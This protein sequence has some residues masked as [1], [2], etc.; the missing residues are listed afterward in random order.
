MLVPVYDIQNCGPRH[1]FA[2]NGKLVHNSDKVNL[3]N[4]PRKSPLKKAIRA[5]DGYLLCDCDSSQI[6]ARV[7]AWMAGQEDL[8]AAFD[9]GE[10]VY[11][12][13]ASSIYSVPVEEVT[14][15]QRFVGKAIILGCGYGMGANKFQM[16]LKSFGIDLALEEC[17]RIIS[18]YR[19]TYTCIPRLWGEADDAINAMLLG[20]S[21]P[22]GREGVLIVDGPNGII[23]PNTM[24]MQYPNLQRKPVLGSTDTEVTYDTRK[25]RNWV[26]NYIYG[27]KCVE[28]LCQAL[29]R[30][31]I[32]EQMLMVARRYKVAMTVHDSV[33]AL[34][35]EV[36]AEEARGYIEDCM[37][38]RPKWAMGLPLNCESKMGK[39]YGG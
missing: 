11:K 4:L 37:R 22:L 28:N 9:R 26:Q 14:D 23:L 13:M 30:I 1:R 21:T 25:G 35:P 3:Q 8:V 36:G 18:V 29:A 16:Q 15:H 12:T 38:I 7:L 6:E 19:R 31:I 24:R 2:A 17:K 33:V 20:M 39:T 27:G 10:D 32:G 5:P 34:V